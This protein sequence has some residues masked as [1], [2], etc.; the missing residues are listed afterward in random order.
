MDGY[1]LLKHIGAGVNGQ[2]V[3]LMEDDAGDKFVV[4][5]VDLS[6]LNSEQRKQATQECE[7]LMALRHPHIVKYRES[8]S[9][10]KNQFT[11]MQYCEGGSLEHCIAERRKS[12]GLPFPE[13]QVLRWLAQLSTALLYCHDNNVLHR[14]IKAANCFLTSDLRNLLL[15]DFGI[16]KVLESSAAVA[17]TIIG[18]P[19]SMSPEVISGR[20]Y[21]RASDVWSLGCLFYEMVALRKPF[22]SHSLNQLVQLVTAEEPPPQVNASETVQKIIRMLL[23]KDPEKRGTLKDVLAI[24]EV[25]MA[26]P[27]ANP[28]TS[29]APEVPNVA[30][31]PMKDWL[32]QH[33]ANLGVI[34]NYLQNMKKSDDQA[35]KQQLAKA[36]PK[37]P[38][39]SQDRVQRQL[40]LQRKK[41]HSAPLAG[42]VP[43]APK[44][45]NAKQAREMR[46]AELEEKRQKI[47]EERER[48]LERERELEEQ[49]QEG[50]RQNMEARRAA[51]QQRHNMN[52][53]P[54]RNVFV[55][56]HIV[57]RAAERDRDRDRDRERERDRDPVREGSPSVAAR[58]SPSHPTSQLQR[59][60]DALEEKRR[61]ILKDREEKKNRGAL[62]EEKALMDRK[63][64]AEK[65][66]KA[67]EMRR[68]QQGAPP[69]NAGF[70]ST[71]K[72]QSSTSSQLMEDTPVQDKAGRSREGYSDRDV[73][74]RPK[75]GS[76][77]TDRKEKDKHKKPAK[78]RA[79]SEPISATDDVLE[80]RRE[81]RRLA[82]DQMRQQ[83]IADRQRAMKAKAGDVNFEICL[84]QHLMK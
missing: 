30:L 73:E 58:H 3:M 24:P 44:R 17:Q 57:D 36:K 35:V 47:V 53:G 83:M 2:G 27:S 42:Q 66:R 52:G 67:A 71:Y 84:P 40:D 81:M 39:L 74:A 77:E 22:S 20:S 23:R 33:Y 8:V 12:G 79:R 72:G 14:D 18:S 28:N 38:E 65:R 76:R 11:V 55:P 19:C 82:Q 54:Q 7:L 6:V 80:D 68:V 34:Q 45:L 56:P 4:K 43:E 9:T 63:V 41:R 49:R 31:L 51:A 10:A 37:T 50:R 69:E 21:N 5:R 62:A 13:Q 1:K 59:E 75:P 16:A 26:L 61:R 32:K 64:N 29:R 60:R 15:G 25:Q 78:V 46:D 70:A 48:R